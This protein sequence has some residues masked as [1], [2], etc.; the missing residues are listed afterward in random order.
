M[1]KI[2]YDYIKPLI[3]REEIRGTEL[4]C[5]FTCPKTGKMIEASAYINQS[6][7]NQVKE[8]FKRGL[9]YSIQSTISSLIYNLFSSFGMVGNIIGSATS[10]ATS[11]IDV[12][13]YQKISKKEKENAIVEAFKSVI[14]NFYWDENEKRW[15]GKA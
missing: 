9:L 12:N 15:L 3:T 10:S 1:E 11:S 4:Y 5:E 14:S 6:T 2:S 8:N 13:T 7:G